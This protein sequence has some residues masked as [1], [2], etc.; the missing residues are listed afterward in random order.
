MAIVCMRTLDI[1]GISFHNLSADTFAVPLPGREIFTLT[2]FKDRDRDYVKDMIKIAGDTYTGYFTKHNHAV[3]CK[4]LVGEKFENVREWKVPA[5][6]I[7]WLNDVL[8]CSANAAQS[9]NNPRYQ[10][11]KPEEP[12]RIDYSLVQHLIQAWKNLFN[13]RQLSDSFILILLTQAE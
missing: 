3:I 10:Q 9:M 5:V 2:G 12:L 8:F 7:Q 6:S 13:I 1:F 4:I 11:L